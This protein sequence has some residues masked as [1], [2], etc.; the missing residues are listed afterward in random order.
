M[1]IRRSISHTVNPCPDMYESIRIEASV[2]VDSEELGGDEVGY[3]L[4]DAVEV[5][6]QLLDR[7]VE[8]DVRE[9]SASVDS[10]FDSYVKH[11]KKG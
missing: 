8:A 10:S 4:E 6:Q 5:A 7:A 1:I 9:A 11:W 3:T 2:E